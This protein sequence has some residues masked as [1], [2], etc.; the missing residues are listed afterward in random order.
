LLSALGSIYGRG[1][2]G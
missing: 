2:H 1:L